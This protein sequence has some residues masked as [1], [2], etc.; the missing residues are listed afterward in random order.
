M[1]ASL[2]SFFTA[3]GALL[4]GTLSAAECEARLGA[5]ASGTARLALYPRLVARQA[6]GALD[7]LFAAAR[8]AGL[9]WD[10]DGYRALQAGYLAAH[11]PRSWSPSEVALGFVDYL[12]AHGAPKDIV[13]LA[14]YART[15]HHVLAAPPCDGTAHLAVV[16][17]LHAVREFALAVKAGTLTAGRPEPRPTTWLLGRHR[18]TQRLV[19]LTPSVPALV[20]LQLVTD[21]AWTDGLL[22][23]ERAHV[24]AEAAALVRLGFLAPAAQAIVDDAACD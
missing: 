7:A 1:N 19:A 20:A 5:S 2:E 6:T 16:Q 11:P 3:M 15:C 10:A 13:E 8:I 24:R 22:V 23:V 12:G 9:T 4:D 14:D 21:G 17:Y 18:D